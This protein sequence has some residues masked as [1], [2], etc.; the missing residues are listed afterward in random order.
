MFK[1]LHIRTKL[2]MSLLLVGLAS[3]L[4]TGLQ[5]YW[6]AR[7]ALSEA[8]F[9]QLTGIRE[10]RS[11]QIQAYFQRVRNETVVIA[12][13]RAI[14]DAMS[15]FSEAF[16]AIGDDARSAEQEVRLR[17]H[18]RDHYLPT[19]NRD[20]THQ[21]LSLSKALPR[22]NAGTLLQSA[23]VLERDVASGGRLEPYA[24]VHADY[25][26]ALENIKQKVGF[27]DILFIDHQ[28][29]FVVYSV[30]KEPDFATSLY[31]GPY[32]G[33][34]IVDAFRKAAASPN[35][36]SVHL[37]D[38]ELYPPSGMH[39]ASFVASPIFKDGRKVGVLVVQLDVHD[40][41]STMTS[42]GHW[43]KEGLGATGETYLVGEDFTMRNDSRFFIQTPIEFLRA[44]EERGVDRF[45]L[46]MMKSDG[47]TIGRQEIRTEAAEN[48]LNGQSDT[49]I[50]EDYRGVSVLSAFA[51]LKIDNLTWAISA[52]MDVDEAF[53]PVAELRNHILVDSVILSIAILLIGIYV[54]GTLSRPV[55]RLSRAIDAYADGKRDQHVEAT[56]SD[57][58]GSLT[59]AFNR[60]TTD[61]ASRDT[62][63]SRAEEELKEFAQQAEL[64][65]EELENFTKASEA[66]V[67]EESTLAA[68]TSRMQGKLSV[69]R[70]SERALAAITEFIGAPVGSLYVLE[71]DSQLYRTAA[72]ALPPDAE[73]L[74]C[75][76]LGIGSVGQAARSRKMA[77]HIPPQGTYPVSF[78][79]GSAAASQIV[80]T[81]LVS[82]N[83]LAGVVE[84]CLLEP[85]TEEQIR[86]LE[87]A[88]EITATSLRLA[89]SE[90]ALR[91]SERQMSQI[92]DFLPDA[93]L[94]IDNEG[95]VVFW[96]R[97]LEALSGAK[98]EDMLGK[99]DQEYAIPFFGERRE[100]LIDLAL[101]PPSELDGKYE[102]I[103]RDGDIISGENY[104]PNLK[105]RDGGEAYLFGIATPLFDSNGETIGAIECI[106]D[107]TDRKRAE[108]ELEE[109]KEIAEAAAK[110][111]ADFLA[112]MSHEIRTPM[113]AIIGMSHLALRTGLDAKQRDY[114]HKIH[115]SGRHLLG[116]INDILD[117]SKI[118]AGKLEVEHVD[119]D[120][121]SVLDNVGNLVGEK[122][123]EKG[124]ELIFDI[125]PDF[126]RALKG[127]ALRI[128]QCLVNYANNAVKFTEKGEVFVRA[129]VAEERGDD[130]L[131]RFEVQDTGIG[132]TPEQKGKLF[133]SFQQADTS[134][135]R[136]YGGTGLGLTI[137]KQL[138]ELMG[139][140]V[141]VESEHGVGSTFWLTALLGKGTEQSK[142]LLPDLDL[143]K[144]RVLTVDDNA[145][146]RE[147]L[148][149]TLKSMSFRVD[150]AA[151]G[152]EA[153][154]SISVADKSGDPYEILF[155]DWHMPPGM[156]GVKTVEKMNDLPLE[157]PPQPIMVT[158]YGTHE[159]S[160]GAEKAG[161]KTTL[162]KP[163][164][165]SQLFDAAIVALGGESTRTEVS[166]EQ[167]V[168]AEAL[169]P[170][171]GARILLT[172]DNLLNQQV[173]S[174]L[175]SDSGFVVDVANNGEEALRM[176]E[177]GDYDVVLMDVQMPVMDGLTATKKIR[178]QE[179][180]SDLPVLAMTAGAM[181]S[182][183][184]QCEEAGMNDHIAKPIEPAQLFGT[185]IKWIKPITKDRESPRKDTKDSQKAASAETKSETA[186]LESVEGLD[187]E[188]GVKRVMGKRDFYE[189]LVK[190]FVTGEEA[191]SVETVRSQLEEGELEAA[192]RTAHSL[193]G[194]AGTIG[195]GE[196]QS[197]AATL[198]A[199][200]KKGGK[201]VESHLKKV[202]QELTRLVGA[203][204]EAMGLDGEAEE[205]EEDEAPLELSSEVMQKLPELAEKLEAKQ[206]TGKELS[207]TLDMGGI[208]SF[209]SEVKDLGEKYSY[210]PVAK[211]A[212]ALTEQAGM[213]D[214]DGIQETLK[215]YPKLLDQISDLHT[216]D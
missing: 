130:L 136:K 92:I 107:I 215:R 194:V 212:E 202:G 57:E 71:D 10:T 86:W 44:Q 78:G 96:N 188:T 169:E 179:S 161:I 69:E 52:E 74:K 168:S 83:D 141:G 135:T 82:S 113:N 164:N 129:R 203:I 163:V 112:N 126:P 104:V 201:R 9:K 5:S 6:D 26:P 117:F 128:G 122:A 68:L 171:K 41:N 89:Q 150:V 190:G 100:I 109:A 59:E 67:A 125:E 137:S 208:E 75:F 79:F 46:D 19:I 172:E 81:P 101:R 158:A 210:P 115:T 162:T 177:E 133:Q 87:K 47:T 147:I 34:H 187:V 165:A 209:A 51:P 204:S 216:N 27:Y 120:F 200:I 124:L 193:K 23:Y 15:R 4:V 180:L 43:E 62:E 151:G 42:S 29:G 157:S 94:V 2:M 199:A 105:S 48:A 160:E 11:R 3:V 60:M 144:R 12:Q 24:Q 183:K 32:A 106:L 110:S 65:T 61:L 108:V 176:V 116:I 38:F 166:I 175:L 132:L 16:N 70:V 143:R 99:G 185:L 195:A 114:V 111:K 8:T 85:I 214:M 149:E 154:E 148:S 155:I 102:Q 40:I 91:E 39:P 76:G 84:L 18:Y 90:A 14:A 156:D 153:L 181:Q 35:E 189:R 184:D 206:D 13:G 49:R 33:T 145:Y 55:L 77:I 205:V 178:E 63:R 198:E 73:V 191:R 174:E 186:D 50:T 88:C 118:E 119:F 80:T 17:S 66:R 167:G 138:A 95:R 140:E 142:P 207:T 182:D 159:M 127:D 58:I 139:G 1:N 152:E 146:A 21:V 36:G 170:F 37:V 56:S 211:W 123:S 31:N 22:T 7:N 97:K 131:V 64:R 213:F 28:T 25:H 93:V 103:Q 72:H 30:L 53:E 45:V 196:L 98:A 173:A 192:E 134:T 121:D 197:R 54:S 20:A